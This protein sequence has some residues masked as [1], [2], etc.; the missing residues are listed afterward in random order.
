[1]EL[2]SISFTDG[3]AAQAG[4]KAR[5]VVIEYDGTPIDNADHFV[6]LVGF[7]PVGTEVPVVF[8]RNG[9]KR[10]TVVAVGDRSEMLSRAERTD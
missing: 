3:P 6:R 10:K 9:V 8:L 4:L 2:R 1:V 7:T 5:D